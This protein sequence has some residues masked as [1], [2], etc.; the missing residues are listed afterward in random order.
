[1]E[2][3]T[4]YQMCSYFSP[5]KLVM[6]SDIRLVKG[7]VDTQLG[8]IYLSYLVPE[9]AKRILQRQSRNTGLPKA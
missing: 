5:V 9:F 8:R 6:T 2:D 3:H 7:V 1:M 4:F